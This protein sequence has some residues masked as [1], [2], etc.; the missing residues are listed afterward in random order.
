MVQIMSESSSYSSRKQ[1]AEA[2]GSLWWIP[3]LRGILLIIVGCYALFRPGMTAAL[4]TQIVAVF[5][6]LDGILAI[7]A[8]VLGETISRG[9]TIARGVL[10]ILIGIFVFGHPV[11]VAGITATVVLYVIAFGAILMGILEIMAAIRDRHEFEGEGWLVLCGAL[12][13]LFGVLLLVAPLTFGQL[14][15]RILGAFAIVFGISSIVLAVRVRRFGRA[16]ESSRS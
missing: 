14:I 10:G 11:V 16:L 4:L 13:I 8:G 2:I 15:V 5:V 7:I 9:W 12:A 1:E 3:L 6:V